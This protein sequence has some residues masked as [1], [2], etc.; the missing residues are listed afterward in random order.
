MIENKIPEKRLLEPEKVKFKQASWCARHQ[1]ECPHVFTDSADGIGVLGAPCILFSRTLGRSKKDLA[2]SGSHHHQSGLES[3]GMCR[4]VPSLGWA[5][6]KVSR[7]FPKLN[8]TALPQ[9]Q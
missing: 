6:G 3:C 5:K 2:I 8:A 9:K 7:T 1:K 4:T